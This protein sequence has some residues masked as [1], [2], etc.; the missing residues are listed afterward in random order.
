MKRIPGEETAAICG[1]F[2][3]TCPSYPDHCK[4]CLSDEVAGD[5]QS[6][7]NGFRDCAREHNAARCFE[8]TA[9]PCERLREFSGRHYVN[10]IGHHKNVIPDLEQMKLYGVLP[11]VEKQTKI[12]T[13]PKCGELIYWH[14]VNCHQ[15]K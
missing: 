13:C 4:G 9:F 15:C 12:H 6:C 14:E 2:C 7:Y 8:C 11:W 10:G 5:C 1:L 3:G